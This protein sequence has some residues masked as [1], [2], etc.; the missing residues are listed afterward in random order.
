MASGIIEK[1]LKTAYDGNIIELPY[2]LPSMIFDTVFD[3]LSASTEQTITEPTVTDEDLLQ[4]ATE[5]ARLYNESAQE[6]QFTPSSFPQFGVNSSNILGNEFLGIPKMS[7]MI[8]GDISDG[9]PYSESDLY[10]EVGMAIQLILPSDFID[11]FKSEFS[12]YFATE[13]ATTVTEDNISTYT[14]PIKADCLTYEGTP[15]Y[16]TSFF[17]EA[18]Y[19]ST[20][21]IIVQSIDFLYE[22]S[23]YR[24]ESNFLRVGSGSTTLIL[25]KTPLAY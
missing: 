1:T 11:R 13:S 12:G 25:Q 17:R 14:V 22:E 10:H 16:A 18:Y 6:N 2:F 9:Y 15:S 5:L 24:Y 8:N 19:E 4:R 7:E 23:R 3:N 20:K 21:E